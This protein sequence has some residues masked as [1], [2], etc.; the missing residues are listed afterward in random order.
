MRALRALWRASIWHPEAVP[1]YEGEIASDVKRGLL[2]VFDVVLIATAVLALRGGMPTFAIVYG[3]AVS[4]AASWALLVV[5]AT[6]LV[7][8]AFPRLWL[9]ETIAK[10]ALLLLLSGYGAVLILSA[11][12]AD[13]ARGFVG[14][15][16]LAASLIPVWRLVWLGRDYRRRK[17]T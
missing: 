1:P 13:P 14:G 5:A 16:T 2:P 17:A 3:D 4:D 15:V 10:T 8:V 12:L 11:A 9:V 6:C 7:G